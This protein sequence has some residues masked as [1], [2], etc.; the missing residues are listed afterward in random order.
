VLQHFHD[1]PFVA[2]PGDEPRDS[3]GGA[4]PELRV[5]PETPSV[6]QLTQLWNALSQPFRLSVVLLVDV[7]AIESGLP[8]RLVPRVGDVQGLVGTAG[9]R[10]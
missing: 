10:P 2:V 8:P 4:S 5:I 7:V 1:Q 6:E 3:F 9:G